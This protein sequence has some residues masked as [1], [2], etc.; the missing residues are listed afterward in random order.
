MPSFLETFRHLLEK[1]GW[2]QKEAAEKLGVSQANVSRW[3][4]G[5]RE[6]G[7]AALVQIAYGLGVTVDELLGRSE[8][9]RVKSQ[10]LRSIST[11]HHSELLPSATLKKFKT[12]FRASD[13]A[14]RDFMSGQVR[15]LFGP[16]AKKILAWLN[17]H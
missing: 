9:S 2:N 3:L 6:P 5:E 11:G 4:S 13:P 7:L 17:A 12:R 16:G 10:G 15:A 8:I 1:R 14:L